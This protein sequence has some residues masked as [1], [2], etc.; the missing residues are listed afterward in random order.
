MCSSVLE[1]ERERKRVKLQKVSRESGK[2]RCSPIYF[3]MRTATGNNDISD[4]DDNDSNNNSGFSNNDNIGGN[5]KGFTVI[6]VV[7]V[8]VDGAV[9]D[10]DGAIDIAI[11]NGAVFIDS[12]AVCEVAASG[13][14][15]S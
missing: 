8:A 7:V 2:Q 9:I 15:L 1:R 11:M 14:V 12:V 13:V 6:C 3:Q 5:R 4:N 10:D